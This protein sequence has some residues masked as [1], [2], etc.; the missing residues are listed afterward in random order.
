MHYT[1]IY[2]YTQ[3][4]HRTCCSTSKF[5]Q[6]NQK[7]WKRKCPGRTCYKMGSLLTTPTPI[8][9]IWRWKT[10]FILF[11]GVKTVVCY[12]YPWQEIVKNDRRTRRT[13]L[14][15][16]G[17]DGFYVDKSHSKMDKKGCFERLSQH[18]FKTRSWELQSFQRLSVLR[19]I[20]WRYLEEVSSNSL[21]HW[22]HTAFQHRLG[23][24]V[25]TRLHWWWRT[26]GDTHSQVTSTVTPHSANVATKPCLSFSSSPSSASAEVHSPEPHLTSLCLGSWPAGRCAAEADHRHSRFWHCGLLHGITSL[27]VGFSKLCFVLG[28]CFPSHFFPAPMKT[29]NSL[30]SP[31]VLTGFAWTSPTI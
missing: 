22:K 11:Y 30:I 19:A 3:I 25:R 14:S 13:W 21:P 9:R 12:Q 4:S 20:L 28:T 27:H 26:T 18:S 5:S 16:S 23:T 31:L 10:W 24:E 2:V 6:E 29:I 17:S 15:I 8:R 7:Q 1:H